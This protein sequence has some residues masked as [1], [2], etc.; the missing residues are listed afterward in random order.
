[1][2]A[3]ASICR[4]L[5]AHFAKEKQFARVFVVFFFVEF[6]GWRLGALMLRLTL[7]RI[8]RDDVH[9]STAPENDL[10]LSKWK[11]AT[12]LHNFRLQFV[13]LDAKRRDTVTR[14]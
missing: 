5:K 4:R 6:K 8:Q 3:S 9:I 1:M 7:G 10:C 12:D 14:V 13:L 11:W 2:W